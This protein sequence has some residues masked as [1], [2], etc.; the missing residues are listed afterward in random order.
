LYANYIPKYPLAMVCLESC[1]KNYKTLSLTLKTIEEKHCL[2]SLQTLLGL[3]TIRFGQYQTFLKEMTYLT[4]G[5]TQG[6]SEIVA[7]Y[8]RY[9]ELAKIIKSR[10]TESENESKVLEVASTLTDFNEKLVKP[11]RKF[12]LEGAMT[13]MLDNKKIADYV[14]VFNDI[15]LYT[16]QNKN[17]R[18]VQG[19]IWMH[20]AELAEVP[21]TPVVKNAFRITH[22]KDKLI[23]V[24]ASQA[25]K[26]E[27]MWDLNSWIRE[28]LRTKKM[29][30][31][32]IGV[33]MQREDES[34]NEIPTIV[35]KTALFL[36]NHG[37][38]VQGIFR[39]SA[40]QSAV[41]SLKDQCDQGKGLSLD[42]STDPHVVSNLMKMWFREL[43]QPL[44]PWDM[45]QAF[46]DINQK[47]CRW[48]DTR[49]S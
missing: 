44:I 45:F 5:Q 35:E 19:K 41:L 33:V 38:V 28:A 26:K 36:I 1:K 14:L 30:G 23:F 32:P 17:Q 37:T 4:K 27:W 15:M 11:E 22:E 12:L 46:R 9:Q 29:F 34:S 48:I 6:R 7:A 10:E 13:V 2:P 16:K 8:E 42:E 18:S 49:K 3:P 40:M 24:A 47:N 39:E 21:D 31:V 43:P 25:Q 20:K